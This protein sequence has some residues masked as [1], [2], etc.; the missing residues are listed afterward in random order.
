MN[1]QLSLPP[2][3]DALTSH[4]ICML[5]YSLREQARSPTGTVVE[6][7]VRLGHLSPSRGTQRRELPI[8]SATPAVL[9]PADRVLYHFVHGTTPAAFQALQCRMADAG[10]SSEPLK[11]PGARRGLIL[12]GADRQT[13]LLCQQTAAPATA[14]LSMGVEANP[15]SLRGRFEVQSAQAKQRLAVMDVCCPGWTSDMRVA[16][17]IESPAAVEASHTSEAPAVMATFR[18]RARIPVSQLL[19]L[20]LSQETTVH[21][22][23]WLPS[24]SATFRPGSIIATPLVW[25]T[26]PS[27]FCVE[28]EVDVPAVLREWKR[29]SGAAAVTSYLCN[30]TSAPGSVECPGIFWPSGTSGSRSSPGT[31]LATTKATLPLQDAP[32]PHRVTRN[33]LALLQRCGLPDVS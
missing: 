25:Q 32:F 23:W 31:P 20:H 15:H 21:D 24:S 2:Y 4:L 8:L 27:T 16:I 19:Q 14:P 13:R 3:R 30:F 6:L 28:V 5:L 9:D 7:E 17:S 33:L 29:L 18:R 22:L 10:V 26:D 1:R 11:G 12:Y